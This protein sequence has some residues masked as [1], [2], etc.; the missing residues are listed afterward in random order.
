[1]WFT[2][3]ELGC[4]ALIAAIILA[5]IVWGRRR[6]L[7]IGQTAL[8]FFGATV[9]SSGWH[10]PPIARLLSPEPGRGAANCSESPAE[11]R[12]AIVALLP[13]VPARV[14]EAAS[15][16]AV[17]INRALGEVEEHD[18]AMA[19]LRKDA[20]EQELERLASRLAALDA[21]QLDAPAEREELRHL[22]EHQMTVMHRMRRRLDL[23][24]ERRGRLL[25]LV[26]AVWARLADLADARTDDAAAE[27]VGRLHAVCAEL[28]A[29][30]NAATP[31]TSVVQPA[32]ARAS[33][34][35]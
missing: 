35:H 16:A 4:V 26:R 34:D 18:R 1:M 3:A 9:D 20:S 17:L 33:T 2:I 7:T 28:A 31:S 22:L 11:I 5:A 24:V 6:Q 29:E 32:T 12:R 15:M 14:A 8:L 13:G 25:V 30:L 10:V 27:V 21:E 23:V 19:T